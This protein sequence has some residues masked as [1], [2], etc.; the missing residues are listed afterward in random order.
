MKPRDDEQ[1]SLFG[2][3]S[4]P[5]DPPRRRGEVGAAPPSEE[6]REL[7]RRLPRGLYLGGSTWSFP[8]WAGTVYD[9]DYTESKLAREGLGAYGRYP[10]FRAAGIDRTFY[11]PVPA[12]ELARYAAQVPEDFRFLV[13]AHEAI[14]LPRFPDR[15]RYGAVRGQDNPQFLDAAYATDAVVAPFV[16]GLGGKAG[17]LLF[18]FG[19]QGLGGPRFADRLHAFLAAL[20]RGPVYAVEVRQRE[21][22]TPAYAEALAA[23]GACP[24]LNV[25]PRMPEIRAQ[26]VLTGAERGRILILRWMLA[27]GTYEE[28][29]KRYAPFNRL[30]APD[31]AARRAIAELARGALAEGQPFLATI[32]NNAEGCAPLSA[33]ELVKEIL[34]LRPG[35]GAD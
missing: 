31:P 2:T 4:A 6:V 15:P 32:N 19:P 1:L 34:A 27:G 35:G 17:A 28:A 3:E 20:P 13:K 26:A 33:V 18:Q 24:C 23:T 16:E 12:E 7:G 9:G 30:A 5:A 22:L 29:G 8:G 14:T 21:L 11:R 10:L 25:Y